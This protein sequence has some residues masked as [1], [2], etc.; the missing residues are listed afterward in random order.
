MYLIDSKV[1]KSLHEGP[2]MKRSTPSKV[3]V[4]VCHLLQTKHHPFFFEKTETHEN[5]WQTFG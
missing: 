2:Q 1:L 4:T 5:K 3:D